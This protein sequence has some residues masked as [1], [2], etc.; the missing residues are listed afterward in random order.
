VSVGLKSAVNQLAAG[1]YT[2]N[3]WF[4]N[5]SSGLAQL[6][7]FT[8]QVDQEL[9]LDGGFEAGDFTYWTLSGDSSIY[10]N[11]YPDFTG[12]PNG[13]PFSSYDGL[14]YAALGQPYDLAYLSQPL[15]TEAGQIYL[16]SF[17]LENLDGST[18]NQFVVEWNT[19]STSPNVIFDQ[20]N[21]GAFGYDN[22]QFVVEAASNT[23]TLQFGFRNDYDFFC[24]DA[25]SVMP[26]PMPNIQAP[27]ISNGSIQL[28]WPSFPGLSYQVQFNPSLA[29]ATWINLGSTITANANSTS[30]SENIGSDPQGFY[31][32]MISQ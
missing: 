13:L 9:V 11:N 29:P 3:L 22:F 18:P 16:L 20:T 28:S 24:L 5:L 23:T 32:V 17:Y 21:M 25:I 10:T 4:T 7:Q 14:Y 12:D 15:P 30:V 19:N 8:V 6:R 1:V 2:A 31:R 27:T 26:V